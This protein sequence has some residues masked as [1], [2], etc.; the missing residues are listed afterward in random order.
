[1][2]LFRQW[3]IDE[4]GRDPANLLNSTERVIG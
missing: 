2:E 3:I 1:V 4:V